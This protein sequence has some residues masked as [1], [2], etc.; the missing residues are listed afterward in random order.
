MNRRVWYSPVMTNIN[1]RTFLQTTAA[2]AATFALPTHNAHGLSPNEKTIRFG[3]VT[4]LWGQHWDL[5]TLISNCEAA[6]VLG[7]ELRTTHKHGVERNLSAQERLAVRKRFEKSTVTMVGIGS[8]ED[9]HHTDQA[10]VRRAIENTKEFL[11]LSADV[12]GSGVKVKPNALPQG[13]PHKK[14]IAQIGAALR[15]IGDE[16]AVLNQEVRVEVHGGGTQ[17]LPIMRAI[18]EAADH[19]LVKVCWNCNKQDLDGEGLVSN[20][21]LV[22]PYFGDTVHVRELDIGTYPYKQL[23]PLFKKTN[24]RGWVLLEARRM[25]KNP[26]AALIAQR[27]LATR[28]LG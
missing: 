14:T 24:Y 3:L 19:P 1:R 10:R 5:E 17:Q 11:R 25:P 2:T 16:A 8:N 6:N 9:Y 7:V 22:R 18:M 21:H 12:G 20:F 15:E 4:Y 26:I 28:L 27:K 13:V 23:M